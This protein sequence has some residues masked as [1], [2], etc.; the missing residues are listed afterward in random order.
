MKTLVISSMF[1]APLAAP[2]SATLALAQSAPALTPDPPVQCADCEAW[3]RPREPFRVFGNTH[4]VGTEG[5]SAVL[6]TAER[7]HILIDGGLPQSAPL[8]DANI[9]KLGFRTEDVRLIVSSHEHFDHVGGLAALQRASRATVAA[10]AAAARALEQGAPTPEDPQA[11]TERFAAIK[12]VKVVEHAEMLRVGPLAITAH[13]TP[14]HTPGA[15]SWTW[16]SCEGSRCLDMVYAD[17]LSAVSDEGFRFS[18]DA[19]RASIAETFRRSLSVVEQLPCDVLLAPH[20]F[21]VALDAKLLE[22]QKEPAAN[23]FVDKDAC[24]RFAAMQR[25]RLDERLAREKVERGPK[26]PRH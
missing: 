22:W 24:R 18:G 1:L 17:S 11:T 2:A 6:V 12:N 9:R 7:G 21:A 5:L 19:A 13:L 3:N 8:I 26:T 16:R 20:P 4:F 23:P 15:T 10:S 14:G 25:K